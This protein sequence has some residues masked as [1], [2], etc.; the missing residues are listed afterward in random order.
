MELKDNPFLQSED[1]LAGYKES[2]ENLKNRPELISFEKLTYEVFSTE[3]GKKF[4][5]Y[6]THTY[7]IPS[8]A[9]RSANN[10][11]LMCIWADGFK[12]FV[13][14]LKQNIMSHEQRIAAGVN[15]DR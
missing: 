7:L 13:R 6:V 15:N 3:Q 10:Y 8:G 14:M 5:D 11:Q 2:I 12:D 4:M 9:D 1:Y